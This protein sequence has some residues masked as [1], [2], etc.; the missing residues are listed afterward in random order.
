MKASVKHEPSATDSC[1]QSSQAHCETSLKKAPD[2]DLQGLPTENLV[3]IAKASQAAI[4][5]QLQATTDLAKMKHLLS[6]YHQLSCDLNTYYSG[7]TRLSASPRP[8]PPPPSPPRS[9][10]PLAPPSRAKPRPVDLSSLS[11]SEVV[12]L[13]RA[14]QAAIMKQIAA[15]D[16]AARVRE[17]TTM[18]QQ[19]TADLSVFWGQASHATTVPARR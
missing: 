18:Y 12:E 4:M 19:L 6:L 14:S 5:K 7:R 10:P 15:T 16:D 11:T 9:L 2:V 13:A 1:M 8:S 3:E 17:L